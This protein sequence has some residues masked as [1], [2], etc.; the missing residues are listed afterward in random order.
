M[1][2]INMVNIKLTVRYIIP[3]PNGQNDISP[4]RFN[5][6]ISTEGYVDENSRG[7]CISPLLY[8]TGYVSVQISSDNG[9]TF[10]RKG[11]WYSGTITI[12]VLFF[13]YSHRFSFAVEMT[14][15]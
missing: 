6:H 12:N 13:L 9:T 11:V 3:W 2:L 4:D 1:H 15:T 14:L 5:N 7:H 10:N 8:E